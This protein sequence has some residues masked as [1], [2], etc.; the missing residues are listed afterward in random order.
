VNAPFDRRRTDAAP[1][2]EPLRVLVVEDEACYRAYAALL[3]RRAG[4]AVDAVADAPAALELTSR[5]PFDAMLID[6]SIPEMTGV[7]LIRQVRANE[8]TKGVYAVMLSGDDRMANKL[9]ALQAGFDDFIAKSLPEVEILAKLAAAL[10]VA[11][12]QRTMDATIRELFGLAAH[13]ELTGLFN[14]RFFV[15]EVERL[16]ARGTVVNVLLFDLDGFKQ[17]NDTYGHLAGDRVLRDVATSFQ[18]RTRP[19]DIV[20][21]FGGDEFVMAI[22]DLD[23][24]AIEQITVRLAE[25]VERLRWTGDDGEF[26][27]GVSNGIASSRLLFEPTLAA[28]LDAADHDMYKNKFLRKNPHTRLLGAL[29]GLRPQSDE[30]QLVWP[31]PRIDAGA[32]PVEPAKPARKTPSLEEG[33]VRL[34]EPPRT[35]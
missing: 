21:R 4:F 12:R 23:V 25:E 7:E 5:R 11:A 29:P 6:Q 33:A 30:V 8:D 16:L 9:D 14:R 17:V 10:R 28:L 34:P 32:T 31:A 22:P 35:R 26:G 13:D 1:D 19:Q 27:V 18:T 15:S 3:A 20:A 24:D 2:A